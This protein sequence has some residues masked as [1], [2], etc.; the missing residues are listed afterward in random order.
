[1]SVIPVITRRHVFMLAAC[2]GAALALGVAWAQTSQP[3]PA[4]TTPSVASGASAAT[5]PQLN[6][7]DIYDRV[8]AAGYVDIREIE[9][10][11]D[12]RGGHYEVKARNA[13]G[14]RVKLYVHPD[15]GVIERERRRD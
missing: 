15:T 12:R 8:E 7:R 13:R 14:E 11:E 1:M 3:A 10:E 5:G 9:Y 6:I 4:L 2:A